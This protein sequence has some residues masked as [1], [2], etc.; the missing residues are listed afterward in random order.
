M[1]CNHQKL[2]INPAIDIRDFILITIHNNLALCL[3]A[4]KIIII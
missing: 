4:K 1:F 3:K 2:F